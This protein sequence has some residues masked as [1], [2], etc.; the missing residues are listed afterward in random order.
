MYIWVAE[1]KLKEIECRAVLPRNAPS[2]WF[3]EE[4]GGDEDA[5]ESC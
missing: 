3:L 4:D 1:H 5:K 2:K